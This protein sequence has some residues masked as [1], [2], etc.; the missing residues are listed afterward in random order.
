MAHSI[1]AQAP[2]ETLLLRE[3]NM[4][5]S[6]VRPAPHHFQFRF[7][8]NPNRQVGGTDD[9]FGQGGT[10]STSPMLAHGPTARLLRVS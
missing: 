2:L 7:L 5:L 6:G 4:S 8:P 1:G 10:T 3:A 9:T